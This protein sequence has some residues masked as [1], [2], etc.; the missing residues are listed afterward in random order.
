MWAIWF[1]NPMFKRIWAPWQRHPRAFVVGQV[2]EASQHQPYIPGWQVLTRVEMPQTWKE[3]HFSWGIA[4][5]QGILFFFGLMLMDLEFQMSSESKIKW[6][7]CWHPTSIQVWMHTYILRYTTEDTAY[8]Y[9]YMY[10]CMHACMHV[11]MYVCM[12]LCTNKNTYM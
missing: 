6:F 10:V 4:W 7:W 9:I 12:Y 8:I 11:C 1:L 5:S 2:A 3:K